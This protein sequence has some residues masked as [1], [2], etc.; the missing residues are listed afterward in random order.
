MALR[1]SEALA[2]GAEPVAPDRAGRALDRLHALVPTLS[3]LTAGGSMGA[4]LI[5]DS[6]S[7]GWSVEVVSDPGS[8]ATSAADTSTAVAAMVEQGARLVL[9]AGGD[10]TA[11]DVAAAIGAATAALRRGGRRAKCPSS[12][13]RAGSRCTPECSP[14]VRR[15]R[16]RQPP[17]SWARPGPLDRA[18]IVDAD[19]RGTR[20]FAL[21][22]VPRLTGALQAAKAAGPGGTD[23]DLAGLGQAIAAEMVPGRLYLLGPGSTV[24]RVSGALGLPASVGGVDAVV[25]GALVATDASEGELLALLA[26]HPAASLVLG[27]VGGQGFLFGR[28]N[29]QLSAAVVD[30]VGVDNIEIIAAAGKVAALDPPVLRIDLDDRRVSE[31]LTGYRRVRTS[32]RRSTVLRVVA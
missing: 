11:R 17:G 1:L 26:A 22:N 21:A 23:G 18:E 28:G 13:S 4:D 6:W 30:A 27:V 19:A 31:Q 15:R 3:V 8:G 29:Q 32:R 16:G 7:D 12:A 9:F 14:P 10:G 25:D 20:V 24:A 5:P 2:A